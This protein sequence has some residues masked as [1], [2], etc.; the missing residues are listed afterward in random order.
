MVMDTPVAGRGQEGHRTA[1]KEGTQWQEF[2]QLGASSDRRV[3]GELGQ[4]QIPA[5]KA[6]GTDLPQ[7]EIYSSRPEFAPLFIHWSTNSQG[8]CSQ[9]SGDGVPGEL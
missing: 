6:P 4:I 2:G 1:G 9:T 5:G 8:N 3:I 7:V